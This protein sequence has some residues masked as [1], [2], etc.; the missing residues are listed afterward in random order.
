[1]INC[2]G[3]VQVLFPLLE[4]AVITASQE[5]KSA[6][7]FSLQREPSITMEPAD[8]WVVVEGTS[9]FAD[10][11][12]EQNQVSG[13]LTLLRN[14]IQNDPLNQEILL[15]SHGIAII[16][17]LL[18]NLDP[19]LV[20]VH[21]LMA[22]QLLIESV[23]HN[24]TQLLRN[25]HQ[26]LL[27]DFRLWS[28]SDFPVRIGHIQYLS[29]IIKDDRKYFRKKYGV[30]YLLDFVRT[31]YTLDS[32]NLQA[33]EA[34][35]IR[36]S[37]LGLTKYFVAKEITFEELSAIMGFIAVIKEEQL[38]IEIFNMLIS[39]LES[40]S[41]GT[42]GKDQ[43]FLLMFEPFCAELLYAL[44]PNKE[45]SVILKQKVLKVMSLLLTTEKVYEKHKTRVRLYD[46]G[47]GGM[48]SLMQDAHVSLA[49]ILTMIDQLLMTY[50]EAGYAGVLSVLLL[51][52]S[53]DLEMKVE[54]AKKLLNA[55]LNKSGA[56]K[57]FAKQTGW[58]DSISR[59]SGLFTNTCNLKYV[60]VFISK[61]CL[62]K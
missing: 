6:I 36:V 25:I 28:K 50:N 10:V 18:Q 34:R 3:G 54:V 41:S 43:I 24:N 46:I 35:A 7:N 8:D 16:G 19:C 56:C 1:M 13:F 58:Q 33:D 22:L 40:S 2:V 27:F 26:Y 38:L 51:I 12:L 14:I 47:Y 60:N 20:D 32:T 42:G 45:Y 49:M 31:Y 30:Q 52:P 29:T 23:T 15:R 57:L 17:A 39:L 4:Q 53:T 62:I 11:H 61:M 59:Y 9:K 44:L 37:L 48:I 5:K 55:L 21:V